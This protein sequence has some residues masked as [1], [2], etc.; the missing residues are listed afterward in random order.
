[1]IRILL[2]S[3][4]VFSSGSLFAQSKNKSQTVDSG[5]AEVNGTKLYYEIAGKG[6]PLVLIHGSFGDRRFWDFQFKE[7]SKKYKV[8]RYDIRGFGRSALPNPDE[9][10]R[11]AEDLNAL[12]NFLRIKKAHI[13]GL[14]F[15]SFIVIDFALSYPDKCISLIP[16]GPRVAGDDLDEYRT[17]NSD[18]LRAIIS[19]ITGILKNKGAKAATD[20]LW[21][22][23]HCMSKAVISSRTRES[24]LKMGYEYSWWRYL[25]ANKREYVF[26]MAIKQLNEIKIPTLVVTAEYD[27]G[28]CKEIAGIM[29]KEIPG[30]KLISIKAAGH[31]MNMDKP[32]EF[33][34]MISGFIDK[35]KSN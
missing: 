4:I 23:G 31:I 7:L 2:I 6:K 10:Y 16:I 22:G 29:A 26:P 21:T 20:Y 27:L 12:I 8:L 25:H 35:V 11:D 1:M 15:G 24:L 32:K 28:L 14:S 33:N 5:Y 19:K 18:T 3:L 13:C 17:P 34:K 9:A 30:A